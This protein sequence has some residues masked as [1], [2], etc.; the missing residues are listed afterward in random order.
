MFSK[1]FEVYLYIQGRI[2]GAINISKSPINEFEQKSFLHYQLKYFVLLFQLEMALLYDA[3]YVLQKSLAQL[4][5]AAVITPRS[6]SCKNPQ[7][8]WENG[9]SLMNFLRMVRQFKSLD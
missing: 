5:N 3:V 8:G 2:S 6:M 7:M 4:Q 1:Q 9:L